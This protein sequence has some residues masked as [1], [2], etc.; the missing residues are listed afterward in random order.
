MKS[1]FRFILGAAVAVALN[2][3]ALP[4]VADTSV[5]VGYFAPSPDTKALGFIASE[6]LSLPLVPI[7]PQVTVAIPSSGGRYVATAEAKFAHAGGYIGAGAGVGLLK[8]N[9]TSGE[10][11]TVF[12]GKRVAPFTSI[13]ARY[14]GLGTKTAGSS[15]FIGLRF[16]I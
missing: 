12:V 7:T 14:Y 3:A 5:G 15:G 10:I 8:K 13:E 9:G 2:L 11:N 4:A 6:G 16:S 1:S